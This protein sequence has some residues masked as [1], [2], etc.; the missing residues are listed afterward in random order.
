MLSYQM[1]RLQ[2]SLCPAEFAGFRL[3][4]GGDFETTQLIGGRPVPYC[5]AETTA[6]KNF[7]LI[8]PHCLSASRPK[9]PYALRSHVCSSFNLVNGWGCLYLVCPFLVS[10]IHRYF[11]PNYYH[12]AGVAGWVTVSMPRLVAHWQPCECTNVRPPTSKR[13]G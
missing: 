3:L 12:P 11:I 6:A 10:C 2:V 5:D 1:C 9:R 13:A 4:M 7:S 8:Y